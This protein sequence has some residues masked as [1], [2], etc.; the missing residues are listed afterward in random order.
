MF[1]TD[2]PESFEAALGLPGPWRPG[3]GVLTE[4]D[5]RVLARLAPG[6]ALW[7]SDADVAGT[8][9]SGG[10]S[11]SSPS[12]RSSSASPTLRSSFASPSAPGDGWH[13]I[14]L[15][16]E[17]PASQFDAL[18]ELLSGHGPRLPGPVAAVALTGRGFHGQRGRS[19][20]SERGN[21]FFCAA[22]GDPF[23]IRDYALALTM[24]PAVV[25]ADALHEAGVPDP[26][27]KWVNDVLVD[28]HKV[29]GVLTA[30]QST[31]GAIDSTVFG[32]GMNVASAP[33]V[34]PTPF[35]PSVAAVRTYV[36]TAPKGASPLLGRILDTVLTVFGSRIRSLRERGPSPLIADYRQSAGWLVGRQ[37][38]IYPEGLVDTSGPEGW[39][40]PDAHGVVTSIRDDLAL[41][42]AGQDEPVQRGRLALEEGCLA[43]GLSPLD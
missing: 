2:R 9:Q 31:G 39:P 4:F 1:L 12:S 24:L 27:I 20:A 30:T 37:V 13:R 8:R 3:E 22:I 42:L 17:A 40:V 10:A 33:S 32:I 36:P 21:L 26:R 14:Y 34:P 41:S 28:G 23:P 11:S 15:I 6:A 43:Y 18:R 35:V 38:R 16:D 25:A 7:V 5:K 19:W 29:A